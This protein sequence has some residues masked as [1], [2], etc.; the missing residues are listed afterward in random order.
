M[1]FFEQQDQSKAKT[2]R[3]V[4]FFI[5][6]L[7]GIGIIVFF[8][9]FIGLV[10]ASEEMTYSEQE[11]AIIF[12]VLVTIAFVFILVIA[13]VIKTSL[14]RSGGGPRVAEELGGILVDEGNLESAALNGV[15]LKKLK[16]L[17]NVNQEM[18]LA[19]GLPVPNLYILN[20]DSVNAFAAGF[21]PLNSVIG[22]TKG[23]INNLSRAE[24][25]GV[26][27]HEYSHIL[28]GDVRIN[29]RFSGIVFGLT[30]LSGVGEFLLRSTRV[31]KRSS[32]NGN[33]GAVLLIIGLA[34]FIAGYFGGVFSNIMRSLI[35]KQ[36][37][38]L[39][40][41]SAVQFTRNPSGIANALNKIR[42]GSGSK[43]SHLGTK[44]FSHMFFAKSLDKNFQN[45]NFSTHPPLEDRIKRIDPS[46]DFDQPIK[47]EKE[48]VQT[49]NNKASKNKKD[50]L[51]LIGLSTANVG[52]I[53]I[54]GLKKAKDTLEEIP[55]TI[56]KLLRDQNT[57]RIVLIAAIMSRT[58]KSELFLSNQKRLILEI[59]GNEF[60]F[61][62]L[63][64]TIDKIQKIS[65]W[66]RLPLINLSVSAIRKMSSAEKN[67]TLACLRGL[68]LA[69][70]TLST[71]E[72]AV[73]KIV[74][75]AMKV[76]EETENFHSEATEIKSCTEIIN[77]MV[78][79]AAMNEKAGD[80]ARQQALDLLN[81]T[82]LFKQKFKKNVVVEDIS[83]HEAMKTID[84]LSSV[85]FKKKEAI[86]KAIGG[87]ITFDK[88]LNLE[89][90]ELQISLYA[91]FGCP[92]PHSL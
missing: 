8:C 32:K 16:V 67:K 79:V 69:D 74:K 70:S 44:K 49:Q 48:G 26:L 92:H 21:T 3:L 42:T 39:A 15:T 86:L 43:V 20:E 68:A 23:A 36:R 77:F 71:F 90:T 83:T 41:A 7:F 63:D 52:V 55:E 2:F 91:A 33:G 57:A 87:V 50:L 85:S 82:K 88:K 12:S 24:L 6:G 19:S 9:V 35:S 28:N 47:E 25:Q 29:L 73:L 53:E 27:A 30:F 56:I 64:E 13:S 45:F 10:I 4:G 58:S 34:F 17:I 54:A 51:N 62:Q 31:G 65:P 60:S 22:V 76:S 81:N 84:V 78:A 89:E 5:V 72:I 40:D 80:R 14:L 37:E 61:S 59:L 46:F 1:N 11:A 66:L 75:S 18:A 38:F